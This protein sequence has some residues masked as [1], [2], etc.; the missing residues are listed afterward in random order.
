[1]DYERDKGRAIGHRTT[2]L[3]AIEFAQKMVPIL[4]QARLEVPNRD[5]DGPSNLAI[6]QWL[7]NN[8]YIAPR[9]GAWWPATISRLFDCHV[10]W[11]DE[12]EKEYARLCDIRRAVLQDRGADQKARRLADLGDLEHNRENEILAAHRLAAALKGVPCSIRVAPP[13]PTQSSTKVEQPRP[14]HLR[15]G[16][17]LDLFK[18]MA[19]GSRTADPRPDHCP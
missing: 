6:I 2:R 11:I 15:K 14:R 3:A 9:G 1:M 17:Q 4:A 7:N 5:A 16:Q 10:G 18:D 12:I 13:P 19:S 8:G